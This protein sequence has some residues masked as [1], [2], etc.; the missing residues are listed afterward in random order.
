MAAQPPEAPQPERRTTDAS[1]AAQPIK[2]GTLVITNVTKLTGLYVAI[3]EAVLRP[4]HDPA[5][6]ALA[7]FMMGGAQIS[8][9]IVMAALDKFFG[10]PPK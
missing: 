2:R 7:A 10:T 5:T 4:H 3:H 1:P 9:G 8:E 6:L